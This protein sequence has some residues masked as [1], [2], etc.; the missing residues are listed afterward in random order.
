MKVNINSTKY[1]LLYACGVVL[2]VAFLLAF[3]SSVLRAPSEANERIDQQ[4]QILAS[5][6]M[7][8]EKSDVEAQYKQVIVADPI[9]DTL[10]NVVSES[11]GF[12]VKRKDI[13]KPQ[14]PVYICQ[15]NGETKYVLPLV[16]KGLWG[17]IWGYLAL[18]ADCETVY[19]AY[20]SHESETAGL[21]A[22]IAEEKFQ[23]EFKGKKIHD[24]EGNYLSV[25]KF[26]AK[27]E[28]PET[29]CDGISGATLTT[30]GVNAMIS[31]YLKLY[32]NFL[33]KKKQN[34]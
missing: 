1:I 24:A 14:L 22:L 16:G 4:K 12:K 5:L 10:G 25:V 20:F 15:I 32:K 23:S 3:F 11:G 19:G 17:T 31:D 26:G 6:N 7:R 30:N 13:G 18:N 8:P 33:N 29:Q 28:H 27:Q 21:G 2:V 34:L 9:V